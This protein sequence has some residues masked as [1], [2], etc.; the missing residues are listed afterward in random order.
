MG[1]AGYGAEQSGNMDQLVA[2]NDSRMLLTFIMMVGLPASG[3]SHYVR[4]KSYHFNNDRSR[5]TVVASTDN[6]IELVAMDEMKTYNQVFAEAIKPATKYCL[7]LVEKGVRD[8]SHIIW[9]QTNVS[10]SSRVSKLRL[11]PGCYFK[12]CVVV[13]C[14]DTDTWNVR[15]KSRIGKQIPD[16]VLTSMAQNFQPPTLAEGFDEIEFVF[17]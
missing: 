17:T 6:Y 10:A 15:L 5:R 12:K 8:K 9:D 13:H 14:P 7:D 4:E 2:K 3:K 1:S 16:H 11:I